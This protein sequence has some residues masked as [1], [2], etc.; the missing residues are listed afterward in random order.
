[1][2]PAESPDSVSANICNVELT[3]A[4][5]MGQVVRKNIDFP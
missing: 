4:M 3:P 2:I 5:V 1:M